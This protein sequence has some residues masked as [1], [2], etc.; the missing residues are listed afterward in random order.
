MANPDYDLFDE[1]GNRKYLTT[2]ERRRYFAAI[3]RALAKPRTRR[4]AP[5]PYCST[6]P[7]AGSARGW[8]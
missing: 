2:E 1:H 5:L 8:P 6:I 4:S 7:A 3:D